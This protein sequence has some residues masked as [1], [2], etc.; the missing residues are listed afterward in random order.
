MRGKGEKGWDMISSIWVGRNLRKLWEEQEQRDEIWSVL[1]EWVQIY[2]SYERNRSRWQG[3]GKRD[4]NREKVTEGPKFGLT[5]LLTI[6][7]CKRSKLSRHSTIIF[8]PTLLPFWCLGPWG[9]CIFLEVSGVQLETQ[10]SR[11]DSTVQPTHE[12]EMEKWREER[13]GEERRGEE[14]RGEERGGKGRGEGR[15]EGRGGEKGGVGRGEG[16]RGG[17][18]LGGW[19]SVK[20]WGGKQ[21]STCSKDIHKS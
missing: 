6:I 9:W 5:N 4:R 15:G 11:L 21:T 19:K 18:R 20:T 12:Q 3:W 16:R 2:A 17:E 8:P 1:Y 14:R 13:R 7:W 10:T